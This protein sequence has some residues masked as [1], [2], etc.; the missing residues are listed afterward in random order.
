[1]FFSHFF[2]FLSF[3][4][5]RGFFIK[6]ILR[7]SYFNKKSSRSEASTT[8]LLHGGAP[9]VGGTMSST[10]KWGPPATELARGPVYHLSIYL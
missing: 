8:Q 7:I 5:A 9:L 2:M 10:P 1:M 3:Y 4:R 6:E